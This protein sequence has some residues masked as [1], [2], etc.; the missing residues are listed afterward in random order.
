MPDKGEMPCLT[1]KIIE[2]DCI[3]I[4]KSVDVSTLC[5]N[6]SK[7]I[8]QGTGNIVV[9][10]D[11]CGSRMRIARCKKQL[12]VQIIVTPKSASDGDAI[13]LVLCQD[14]LETVIKNANGLNEGELAEGLL[15]LGS[16]KVK[17]NTAS[18]NVCYTVYVGL[19]YSWTKRTVFSLKNFI[20]VVCLSEV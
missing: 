19:V 2:V 7:K 10:C 13:D 3:D 5:L 1:E 4:V 6:C 11:R 17:Y 12:S 8:L 9:H 15:S 20:V 16:L 14:T 18:N